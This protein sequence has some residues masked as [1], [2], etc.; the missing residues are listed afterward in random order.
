[1]NGMKRVS[2]ILQIRL[3]FLHA[4][5]LLFFLLCRAFSSFTLFSS[6][7]LLGIIPRS[8]RLFGPEMPMRPQTVSLG[9]PETSP[10][11]LGHNPGS[12]R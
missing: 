6:Y 10:Q 7:L 8:L 5:S 3:Y 11:G 12:L 1:M 9:P 4:H 2:G